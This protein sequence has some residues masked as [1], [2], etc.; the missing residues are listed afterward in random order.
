MIEIATRECRNKL[1][2]DVF[3]MRGGVSIPYLMRKYQ[4]SYEAAYDL[5]KTMQT[6]L[7][8]Q[9]GTQS[10]SGKKKTRK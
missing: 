4:M 5:S 3:L 6:E 7:E 10:Q 1:T 2:I 8:K 9:H